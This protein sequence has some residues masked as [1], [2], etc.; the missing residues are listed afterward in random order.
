EVSQP[1]YL[2]RVLREAGLVRVQRARNGELLEPAASKAF[3]ACSHQIAHVYVAQAADEGR[4]RR[5]LEAT[6]GVERVLDAQAQRE[7]G[8]AHS[9]S[10]ELVAVAAPGAWFAYPYWLDDAAAPDFARCVA[11]HDKPG[12]DPMEMFFADGPF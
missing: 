1:V 12:H 7:A 2:N 10:G 4:V 8:L 11:I 9:R 5:L 3:A 6:D